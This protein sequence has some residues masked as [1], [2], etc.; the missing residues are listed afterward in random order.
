MIGVTGRSKGR[1]H[2]RLLRYR[3]DQEI[4]RTTTRLGTWPSQPTWPKDKCLVRPA[5]PASWRDGVLTPSW[6]YTRKAERRDLRQHWVAFLKSRPCRD[7]RPGMKH[8][9]I[10]CIRP[11]AGSNGRGLTW[12]DHRRHTLFEILIARI[13]GNPEELQRN[14]GARSQC[15]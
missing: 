14:L 12:D 9:A 6:E 4:A 1:N 11:K 7:M 15:P 2:R 5:M 13:S 3:K 10:A 8:V